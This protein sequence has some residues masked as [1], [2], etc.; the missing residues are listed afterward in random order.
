MDF[1][2]LYDTVVYNCFDILIEKSSNNAYFAI[3]NEN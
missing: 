2:T 1:K 3:A